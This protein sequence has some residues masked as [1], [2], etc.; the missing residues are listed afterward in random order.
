MAGSAVNADSSLVWK[1]VFWGGEFLPCPGRRLWLDL[2]GFPVACVGA[3]WEGSCCLMVVAGTKATCCPRG[4]GS[5]GR[6]PGESVCP[7]HLG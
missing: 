1:G 4:N 5:N 6:S 3:Q 7:N 2:P